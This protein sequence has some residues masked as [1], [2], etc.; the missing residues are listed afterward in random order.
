M[1]FTLPVFT[2]L[3]FG[4]GVAAALIAAP[5][6]AILSRG[7]AQRALDGLDG[8]LG[9]WTIVASMVFAGAAVTW[10]GFASGIALVAAGVLGLTLHE[11]RTEHVVHSLE[12]ATTASRLDLAGAHAS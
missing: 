11:L 9:T 6:V 7:R 2:W 1:A 10:L 5:G 4:V 8:L 3:M 12:P